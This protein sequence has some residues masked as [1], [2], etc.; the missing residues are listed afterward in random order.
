MKHSRAVILFLLSCAFGVA[1]GQT[2]RRSQVEAA[3]DS[4]SDR[5]G[6]RDAIVKITRDPVTVLATIAKS[7]RQPEIRRS[8][9][10]AL[11]GTFKGASSEHALDQLADD[12]NP[13]YRCLALQ[14]IAEL[15]SHSALPVLIRKLDDQAVCMKAVST[16]PAEEHQV[17]VSDEA[18]RL[19]AGC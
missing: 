8:H 5:A 13:K 12:G 3:I 16:D 19:L 9:A 10:I 4:W 18:V 17:Y 14:S 6:T 2:S 7:N 11:L 1:A 15:K